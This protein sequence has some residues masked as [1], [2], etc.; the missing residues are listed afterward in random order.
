MNETIPEITNPKRRMALK[1]FV[2]GSMLVGLG[3]ALGGRAAFAATPSARIETGSL[4]LTQEWDKVF[5]K[6]EKID[7]QKVTFKNRYGITLAVTCTC[8][9]TGRT[10]GWRHSSSGAHSAR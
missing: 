8:R 4:R 1:G 10:S 2:Q 9:R 5:P 7:H 3:S 6:S